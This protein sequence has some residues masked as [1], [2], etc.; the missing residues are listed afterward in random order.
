MDGPFSPVPNQYSIFLALLVS[1]AR[2][3]MSEDS[4]TNIT[5]ERSRNC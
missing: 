4:Y 5:D 3:G 2:D 1:T